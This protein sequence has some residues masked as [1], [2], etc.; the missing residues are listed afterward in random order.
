VKILHVNHRDLRHP[1][2]GGLEIVIHEISCRWVKA[3]HEVFIL[4]SGY[5][6]CLKEEVQDGIRIH[7]I[8]REEIFNFIAGSWLI[9]HRWLN[10]DVAIEHLAK[11]A[12]FLPLF[13]YQG[14][15]LAHVPHLFGKAIF[16]EV[17]WPLGVYVYVMERMLP[18][19]YGKCPI[20]ALSQSTADE[21]V[22]RGFRR[23]RV[24]VVSGGLNLAF[25][26]GEQQSLKHPVILYVGR[27]KKY[28]GLI[29]PLL[30][31]WS[32]VSR[33][34]PDARLQIVGKGDYENAIREYIA[35]NNL[36]NSVEML[37]FVSEQQKLVLLRSAW[38]L[39]YPSVKEGWGLPIIEGGA[40]GIPT[41]ASD[42]PGLRDV[43]R[44]E[45]TGLLVP[46]GNV[47][48]MARAMIRLI[49]DEPLRRFLGDAAKRWSCNFDWDMMAKRVLGF[50]DRRC[51]QSGS[52]PKRD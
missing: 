32:S 47:E 30:K 40:V 33:H 51:S 44:H 28:K 6:G 34:R 20:W 52:I 17:S 18:L 31:A 3:G 41:V 43:V 4:C 45:E 14:C 12:C 11:V 24:D 1:Q 13:P 37:G 10:A 9:R 29:H 16:E 42:S 22:E 39:V 36:G 7:R 8:G 23:D 35:K 19:I 5:P 21:L 49:E 27:L 15:L 46:H 48:A 50:I 25:F 2:A 38:F 26:K